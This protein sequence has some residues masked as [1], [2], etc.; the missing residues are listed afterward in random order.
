M[1]KT[2]AAERERLNVRVQDILQKGSYAK[3]QLLR[4]VR[5]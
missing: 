2:W 1:R 4:E 5:K 3:E